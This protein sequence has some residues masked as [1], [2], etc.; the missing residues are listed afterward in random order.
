MQAS[1]LAFSQP[2]A[3]ETTP[4]EVGLAPLESTPNRFEDGHKEA[5][6]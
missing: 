4:G 2:I 3:V 5:N 1:F 6:L